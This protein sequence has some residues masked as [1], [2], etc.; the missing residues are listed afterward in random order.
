MECRN[1]REPAPRV[2]RRATRSERSLPRSRS[3]LLLLVAML[4]LAPGRRFGPKKLVDTRLA[5][6]RA[7]NTT[8]NEELLLNLVRLRY[9]ET[10][11]F[12]VVGSITAQFTLE[13]DSEIAGTLGTSPAVDLTHD[14][15]YSDSPTISYEPLQ[16]GDLEERMFTP[17]PPR[18][19]YFLRLSG[20]RTDRLFTLLVQAVNGVHN[21]RGSD[22]PS[23]STVSDD[24]VFRAAVE[25]LVSLERDGVV[26]FTG[27]L[28]D[29]YPY[30][31][32]FPVDPKKIPATAFIDAAE[33]DVAMRLDK[34]GKVEFWKRSPSLFVQFL[35]EAEHRP[36]FQSLA[37]IFDLEPGQFAFEIRAPL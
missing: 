13:S 27:E 28:H 6:N 20:W 8:E 11:K 33:K 5:Y 15:N 10:I 34:D 36:E 18:A 32:P 14:R 30:H 25:N 26:E 3:I 37:K 35:P 29:E 4:T 7:Y 21:I 22:E 1:I 23:P 9:A 19:L 2:W 17:I 12:I 16:S 24:G 31:D